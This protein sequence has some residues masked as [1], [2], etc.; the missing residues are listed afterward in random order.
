MTKEQWDKLYFANLQVR[1]AKGAL[2]IALEPFY[3]E[4]PELFPKNFE[5]MGASDL[6]KISDQLSKLR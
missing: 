6:M 3:D 4:V 1:E 2:Q 5:E